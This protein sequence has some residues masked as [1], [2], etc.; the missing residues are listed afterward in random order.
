MFSSRSSFGLLFYHNSQPA[1]F[2]TSIGETVNASSV[3]G[4]CQVLH[5]SEYEQKDHTWL[6][7]HP[8]CFYVLSR[9]TSLS[10]PLVPL[11]ITGFVRCQICY[12]MEEEKY[13]L[14]IQCQTEQQLYAFDPFAGVGGFG[15]GL[16]QG[17]SMQTLLGVDND[18]SAAE[19][20]R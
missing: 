11:P 6:D 10:T 4:T 19:T 20:M 13:R 5:I 17:C 8:N 1:L 16:A 2:L 18:A 14:E 7:R 12:Q 15:L 3:L 9:S